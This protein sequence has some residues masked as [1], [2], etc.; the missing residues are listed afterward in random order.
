MQNCIDDIRSWMEDD[1]LLLNDEKT[2]FLV[3]GTRQ[4]L[5]K[6]HISLITMGNSAAL[7][8]VCNAL[9]KQEAVYDPWEGSA[10]VEALVRAARSSAHE[11]AD[12]YVEILDEL[13][14]RFNALSPSAY[15]RLLVGL[16]GDPVRAKVA[17]ESSALLRLSSVKSLVFKVVMV[18]ASLG[19]NALMSTV[20]LIDIDVVYQ[21]ISPEILAAETLGVS[22]M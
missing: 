5:S 10:H 20:Q 13:K 18:L 16:L 2:E 17:K 9:Q 15:K 4:Q 14:G 19:A 11:K 8:S 3:I 1:K 22:I 21:G 7:T 6:L 12:Y